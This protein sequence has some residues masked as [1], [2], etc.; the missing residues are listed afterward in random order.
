VLPHIARDIPDIVYL[1]AGDGP[2]R[3]RLAEKARTLKIEDRVVFAGFVREEEKADHYRLADA[4]VMPSRGEGFGI[5]FL[6][7][8]ACGIPV[9]GSRADAG[10]EALRDGKLGALVNPADNK[11]ILKAVKNALKAQRRIPEGLA[12]FSEEAFQVRVQ[13]MLTVVTGTRN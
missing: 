10:R 1:I 9:I 2:D 4:Y 3:A 7:A 6:E 11:E 12:Y 8:M 13:E 5:V